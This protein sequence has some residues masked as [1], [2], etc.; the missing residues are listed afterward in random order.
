MLQTSRRASPRAEH[1]DERALVLRRNAKENLG[2][3]HLPHARSPQ[4][5]PCFQAYSYNNYPA[6]LPAALPPQADRHRSRHVVGS[7][8]HTMQGIEIYKV[9]PIFYN[10]GTSASDLTRNVDS[11]V[12]GRRLDGDRTLGAE[13][14]GISG[15]R[16]TPSRISRIRRTGMEARGYSHLPVRYRSP[17]DG[18]GQGRTCR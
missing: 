2:L 9:R 3:R 5:V 12:G 6:D 10:Q 16:A 1:A 13:S 14:G 18:R 17:H 8:V 7:G 4:S 11:T 15:T